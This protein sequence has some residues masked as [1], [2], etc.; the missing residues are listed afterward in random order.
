VPGACDGP[1]Q[2]VQLADGKGAQGGGLAEPDG[3][4]RAGDRR[5]DRGD[6]TGDRDRQRERG[7]HEGA[8]GDE[9]GRLP[10]L[11]REQDRRDQRAEGQGGGDEEE[12]VGV[13][14]D[15]RS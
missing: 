15:R 6:P 9:P 14:G 3:A 5:S 12:Q 2:L 13:Q 4:R 1:G 10:M 11:G 7:Q 8:G